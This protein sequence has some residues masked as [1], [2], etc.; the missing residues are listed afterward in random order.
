M[1]HKLLTSAL[2][3]GLVLFG[4]ASSQAGT[5][6]SATFDGSFVV[7][8]AGGSLIASGTSTGSTGAAVQLTVT[9][10]FNSMVSAGTPSVLFSTTMS[11]TQALNFAGGGATVNQGIAGGVHVDIG[12]LPHTFAH[13]FTVP[14]SAGASKFTAFS[15]NNV[16]A[17]QITVSVTFVGW[18][19]GA[20][21]YVSTSSNVAAGTF[22]AA[23]ANNLTANGGG[24]LVLIAPSVVTQIIGGAKSS[25]GSATTLTLNFVGAVTPE[26]G[27]LVLLGAGMVGLLAIGRRRD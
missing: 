23:G 26:P 11:G 27:T 24:T 20:F 7:D 15:V 1:M 10:Q 25:S 17:G 12:G 5:L 3:A 16:L 19:T 22:T 21:T 8:T 9:P 6:T 4:A 18:Q 13:L 14:L 2:V